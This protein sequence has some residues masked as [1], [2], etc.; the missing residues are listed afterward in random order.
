[1]GRTLLNGI[2][3][4][5][6]IAVVD[7]GPGETI[8]GCCSCVQTEPE[9]IPPDDIDYAVDLGLV[10]KDKQLRIANGIYREVIPRQLTYSN[11]LTISHESEWYIDADGRVEREY[12]LG[13]KRIDLHGMADLFR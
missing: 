13:R 6:C 3:G 7:F 1:M 5:M 8:E 11:Q 10:T 12:G 2:I 9:T 4:Y